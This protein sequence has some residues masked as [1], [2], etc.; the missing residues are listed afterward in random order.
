MFNVTAIPENFAPILG[1]DI[2][3]VA[4]GISV[5]GLLVLV[6][7]LAVLDVKAVGIVGVSLTYLAFTTFMGWFPFWIFIIIALLT[8]IMVARKINEQMSG[9]G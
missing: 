5:I 2:E 6:L 4:I 9:S 3:A 1:L 8:A 7:F